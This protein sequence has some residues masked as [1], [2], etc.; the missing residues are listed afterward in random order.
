MP[1]SRSARTPNETQTSVS[2]NSRDLFRFCI[3]RSQKY[4]PFQAAAY[5]RGAIADKQSACGCA[6]ICNVP[7][8]EK[9]GELTLTRNGCALP[10]MTGNQ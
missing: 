7:F 8:A 9:R 3:S 5:A 4:P 10:M 6:G 1:K 2:N